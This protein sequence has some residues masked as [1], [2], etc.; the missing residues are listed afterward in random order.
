MT[1]FLDYGLRVAFVSS[2]LLGAK[3]RKSLINSGWSAAII[4]YHG[5]QPLGDG[6]Q[7]VEVVVL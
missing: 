6:G 3:S 2:R 4:Y 7:K 5:G 1:I